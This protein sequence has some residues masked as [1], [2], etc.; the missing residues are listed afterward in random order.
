MVA[1]DD[2]CDPNAKGF[3]GAF[4]GVPNEKDDAGCPKGVDGV[5]VVAL[6]CDGAPPKGLDDGV[7]GGWPKLK[8]E[9]ADPD[10]C[11]G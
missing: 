1:G 4:E 3:D 9:E 8:G 2:G 10:V 5:V 7:D 6:D 11:G